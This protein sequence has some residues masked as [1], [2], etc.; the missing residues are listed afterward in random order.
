MNAVT[1]TVEIEGQQYPISECAWYF[2]SPCGCTH[3]VMTTKDYDT[4]GW[5]TTPEQALVSMTP[6]KAVRDQ[7]AARG[8]RAELGLLAVSRERL[9]GD[10]PHTPQWGNAPIPEGTE[11]GRVSGGRSVHIVDDITD[12]DS[13]SAYRHK[14]TPKCSTA[15]DWFEISRSVRAEAPMCKKCLKIGASQ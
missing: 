6:S 15:Q 12:A 8:E 7:D 5:Y 1:I 4:G 13:Q 10:C 14:R 2:I 11:W 9:T 3:G